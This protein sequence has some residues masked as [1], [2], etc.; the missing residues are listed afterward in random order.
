VAFCITPTKPKVICSDFFCNALQKLSIDIGIL[1]LLID[2]RVDLLLFTLPIVCIKRETNTMEWR[3]GEYGA[4]GHSRMV[5]RVCRV[6]IFFKFVGGVIL[7][8]WE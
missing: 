2:L 4:Y 5:A 7:F 3:M 1:H 8:L 6:R